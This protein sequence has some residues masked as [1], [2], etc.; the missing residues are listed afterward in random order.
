M[1]AASAEK[2]MRSLAPDLESSLDLFWLR[3]LQESI[4]PGKH[5]GLLAT[6]N[7][8]PVGLIAYAENPW[9]TSIIGKKA[10]IVSQ[11]VVA[12]GAS[13]RAGIARGLLDGLLEAATSAGIKFLV[14]KAYTD[15]VA[16][17]HALEQHGFLLMDTVVDCQFDFRR[18]ALETVPNPLLPPEVTLRPAVEEDREQLRS[19]ARLAFQK[20]FGRFHADERIGPEKATRFYEE[21]ISSS[22]DGYADWIDVAEISGRIAA[23]SAWKRPS[24]LE[25]ELPVRVGHYSISGIHPQFHGQG[26]F[27]ALTFRGMSRMQPF[28]DVVEGPTHIN[29]HGVQA[30]YSKLLWR[31][32]ADARHSFHKWID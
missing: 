31:V 28:A 12:H 16:V 32:G 22:M 3:T 24:K 7:G 17:I 29:N 19:T 18:T 6:R 25:S 27:T 26:L 15:D 11:F 13:G 30:G 23:F 1:L 10:G 2:P 14:G 8:E 20:H 4:S 9:E 21:W 5:K